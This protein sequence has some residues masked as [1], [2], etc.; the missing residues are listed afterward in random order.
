MAPRSPRMRG[1]PGAGPTLPVAVDRYQRALAT[2]S[3]PTTAPGGDVPPAQGEAGQLGRGGR[4]DLWDPAT[5]GPWPGKA[6]TWGQLMRQIE[7]LRHALVRTVQLPTDLCREDVLA[8]S[9]Q[10]DMLIVRAQQ[11]LAERRMTR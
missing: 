2:P 5:T 11:A 10:L 9:R 4:S 7:E 1:T 6:L 8:L 3:A